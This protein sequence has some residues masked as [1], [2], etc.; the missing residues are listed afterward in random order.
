MSALPQPV[1]D[2]AFKVKSEKY[3]SF[4]SRMVKVAHH[5]QHVREHLRGFANSWKL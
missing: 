2:D 3:E 1:H 5:F 4:D